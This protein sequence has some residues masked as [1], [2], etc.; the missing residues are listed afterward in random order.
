MGNKKKLIKKGIIDLFPKDINRFYDLFAGSAVVSM[1]TKAREYYVNDMDMNL[2]SLYNMFKV[3]SGKEIIEH[4][5]ETIDEYGLARERTSHKVFDDDRIARYKDAYIKFRNYYNE[6]KDVLDL[7]TLIF[8]SF[9]Q[10]FRFNSKGQFNMPCGNDCFSESNM[11]YIFNGCDFFTRNNVHISSVD[12]STFDIGK[13]GKDDFIYLDPPYN[14]TTATY[15]EGCGWTENNE[16][17][18]Y[19]FCERL[20][21]LNIRFGMSNIFKNRGEVNQ[22]LID[23]CD[24]NDWNVYSYDKVK[25]SPCGRGNSEAKEVLITNY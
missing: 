4:I 15:N 24:K 20:D 23:W 2:Y 12:Y 9:S 17:E 14:K 13:F 7:Y 1:N 6:I 18:L 10:Q 25:Y 21:K 5:E 19:R 11:E 16:L 8:Y 3:Y 22:M